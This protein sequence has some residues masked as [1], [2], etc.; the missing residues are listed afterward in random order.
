MVH[1]IPLFLDVGGW[2]TF[3]IT[4]QALEFDAAFYGIS[5]THW[6]QQQAL[7]PTTQGINRVRCAARNA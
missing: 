3:R 7:S 5:A 2:T 6:R 1:L 4:L